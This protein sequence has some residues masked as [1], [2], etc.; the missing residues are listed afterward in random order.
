MV[1]KNYFISVPKL[2]GV[3]LPQLVG[4]DTQSFWLIDWIQLVF[5]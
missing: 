4:I 1:D 3:L 5:R 2:V